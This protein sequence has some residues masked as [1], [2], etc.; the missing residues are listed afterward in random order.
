LQSG[1]LFLFR[2][3]NIASVDIDDSLARRD[4]WI[5]QGLIDVVRR[6][7][8]T[9][10]GPLWH[11]L[12]LG[13][14]ILLLGMVWSTIFK[15]DLRSYFLTLTPTLIVWALVSS[16]IVEGC[17]VFV[18]AQG[19]ALSIRFPFTAF[20]F[21]HLWRVLLVFFHHLLLLA[22]VYVVFAAF[23]LNTILLVIPGLLVI[24]INGFWMSLLLSILTL[25]ARD[26]Q[27]FVAS[28]M[29]IAMFATPVF[30]P[31][32]LLGER[33]AALV[34]YNPLYHL[35][36][37]GREPLVGRAPPLESWLWGATLAVFGM[38]FTLMLFGR[39]R[40]RLTYWY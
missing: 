3:L 6:Y 17:G 10:I 32:D 24:L 22:I 4:L 12:H 25:R 26:V 33:F 20:T 35:L 8:R 38:L 31:R 30:W 16:M 39:V 1:I 34:D 5:H 18:A 27:Q 15:L 9:W 13:A 21:G 14:M 7:R 19:T 2:W 37:L 23:P 28:G 36:L 40:H 29:Q 11:T